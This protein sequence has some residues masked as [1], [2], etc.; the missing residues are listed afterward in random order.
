MPDQGVDIRIRTRGGRQAAAE[1]KLVGREVGAIGS[2]ARRSAGGLRLFS[3]ASVSAGRGLH[4][5]AGAAAY[6]AA[7]IGGLLLVELKRST[8]AW[9]ETRKVTQD[10]D[11]RRGD[12]VRREHAADVHEHPQ[13]GRQGQRHLHQATKTPRTCRSRSARTARSRR[14]SSARR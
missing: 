2:S 13:R 3:R 11:R 4:V 6:G 10:G 9:Q 1:A 5:A 12:P 8:Q 14:S 7:A